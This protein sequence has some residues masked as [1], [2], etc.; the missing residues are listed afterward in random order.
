MDLGT[1]FSLGF[2]GTMGYLA[3]QVVWGLIGLAIFVLVFG[4]FM[5]YIQASDRRRKR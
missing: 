1:G 3:A 5:L 4:G 2:W